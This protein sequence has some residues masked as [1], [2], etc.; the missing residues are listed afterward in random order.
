MIKLFR[1]DLHSI[2]SRGHSMFRVYEES[3]SYD[4]GDGN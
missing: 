1:G 3:I 4:K 2:F